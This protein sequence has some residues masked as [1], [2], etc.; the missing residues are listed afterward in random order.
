MATFSDP[1]TE[2]VEG[3]DVILIAQTPRWHLIHINEHTGP[4]YYEAHTHENGSQ[5]ERGLLITTDDALARR[6]FAAASQPAT[7]EVSP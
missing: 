3:A 2:E 4:S 1:C 6:W 5:L 7:P